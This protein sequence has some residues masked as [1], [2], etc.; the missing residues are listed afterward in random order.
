[1]RQEKNEECDN[2]GGKL[3][4]AAVAAALVIRL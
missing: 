1:M 3:Y 2:G 4:D